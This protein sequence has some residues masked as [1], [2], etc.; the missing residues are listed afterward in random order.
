MLDH[1]L[2]NLKK[3]FAIDDN[4]NSVVA[5]SRTWYACPNKFTV[6]AGMNIDNPNTGSFWVVAED[7]T[8][9]CVGAGKDKYFFE[10]T[11]NLKFTDSGTTQPAT[12]S[13]TYETG[14]APKSIVKNIIW[15]GG[16]TSPSHFWQRFR[17]LLCSRKE[18]A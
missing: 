2:F 7:T 17:L 15:G 11:L 9:S 16:K 5:N 6:P 14:V 18:V 8:V 1:M 4:A 13:T 10:G 12:Y 3:W